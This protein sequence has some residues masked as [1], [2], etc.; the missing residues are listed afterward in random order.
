ML[1]PECLEL[2]FV[3]RCPDPL[4]D[5]F[6]PTTPPPIVRK[7]EGWSDLEGAELRTLPRSGLNHDRRSGKSM[8]RF[9]V[10]TDAKASRVPHSPESCAPLTGSYCGKSARLLFGTT[11]ELPKPTIVT[12]IV[13]RAEQSSTNIPA[14]SIKEAPI[15]FASGSVVFHKIGSGMII[16]T[17]SVTTLDENV[18]QTIETESAPWH[19]SGR[20]LVYTGKFW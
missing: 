12:N 6:S 9:V 16:R 19:N 1:P 7:P 20:R 18:L 10:T 4:P 17:M 3:C 5:P 11:T 15:F 14:P 2:F 8:G 13:F